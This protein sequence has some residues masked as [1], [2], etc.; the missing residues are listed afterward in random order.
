MTRLPDQSPVTI[1]D[2]IF[3]AL[4]GFVGAA[5]QFDDITLLLMRRRSAGAS[6]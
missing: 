3:S 6:A 1:V 5:Q 4:D 2:G